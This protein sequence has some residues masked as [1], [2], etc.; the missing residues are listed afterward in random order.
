M[1][2]AHSYQQAVPEI[3]HTH[4][5][6][7][8]QPPYSRSIY[9]SSRGSTRFPEARSLAPSPLTTS[10][11][12]PQYAVSY[13]SNGS[14]TSTDDYHHSSSSS[15]R[16]GSYASSSSS[17]TLPE[18]SRGGNPI[19]PPVASSHL[20]SRNLS[21]DRPS[22]D[23]C[24]LPP[25]YSNGTTN[26]SS[27]N[28]HGHAMPSHPV[29]IPIRSN[30]SLPR[31][32][33]YHPTY[34]TVP[35]PDYSYHSGQY[36]DRPPFSTGS[37]NGNYPLSFDAGSDYGDPKQK[38]RRGNLPKAVTDTLRVW[39]TN[40]VGHPYPTEEEKQ[41]LMNMTGLTISQVSGEPF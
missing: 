19:L 14:M 39:F 16:R 15:G 18:L 38:R 24:S 32:A 13:S 4:P 6:S 28:P 17:G 8:R 29:H 35:P 30:P 33:S 11:T 1:Q 37:G 36:A 31:P 10:K 22:R 5:S 9:D 21:A 41:E 26:G 23:A 27:I 20:S 25:I 12:R 2:T 40:H 3:R 34:S 7:E